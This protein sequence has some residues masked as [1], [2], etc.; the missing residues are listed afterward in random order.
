MDEPHRWVRVF[1]AYSNTTAHAA[2]DRELVIDHVWGDASGLDAFR[3]VAL[4]V[5]L[6]RIN[7]G[8]Q[9]IEVPA[10]ALQMI[11]VKP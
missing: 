7:D 5:K 8:I 1:I 9:T 10:E 11:E 4:D 6:P 3:I 2:T